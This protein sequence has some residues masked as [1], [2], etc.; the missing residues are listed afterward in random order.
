MTNFCILYL[1]RESRAHLSEEWVDLMD[2]GGLIHISDNLFFL[3]AAMEAEVKS[4]FV[5]RIPQC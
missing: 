3:F 1:G 4:H 5:L 2:K